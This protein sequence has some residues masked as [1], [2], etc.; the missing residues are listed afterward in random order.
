[1]SGNNLHSVNVAGIQVDITGPD[2]EVALVLV[3]GSLDRK[4]GMALIARE[5]QK[6]CSVIRYDRRGYGTSFPHD[7]PFS[8]SSN[9]DDLVEIV[10]NRKVVVFGHSFGGHMALGLASRSPDSVLAVAT[11]ESPLS[12]KSWWTQNSAGAAAI[13]EEPQQAAEAFM[14]RLIGQK[15]WD[16]LPEKTKQ[17]RR[18]EGPALIGELSDLRRECPWDIDSITC[19]VVVGVGDRALEHHRRGAEWLA[20]NLPHAQLVV[21][22]GAGHGAHV[23]HAGDVYRSMIRPLLVQSNVILPVGEPSP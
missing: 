17:A 19:P 10:G 14:I 4:A 13:R 22:D 8:V 18:Q 15:R 7:G 11:Y 16:A 12:W 6:H 3:H 20:D 21:I 2:T 9:I 23:S 1:M 5:A